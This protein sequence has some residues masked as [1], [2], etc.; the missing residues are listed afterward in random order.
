MQPRPMTLSMEAPREGC[1]AAPLHAFAR[2]VPALRKCADATIN[3]RRTLQR[4]AQVKI[5]D[6]I[7]KYPEMSL[8]VWGTVEAQLK[9]RAQAEQQDTEKWN[10]QYKKLAKLPTYWMASWLITRSAG[11]VTPEQFE[12]VVKSK[13]EQ[14]VRELFFY[15]SQTSATDNLPAECRDKL[16]CAKVFHA[17]ADQVGDRF[18][19]VIDSGLFEG[20]NVSWPDFGPYQVVW[21]GDRAKAINHSS[22]DSIEINGEGEFT[23]KYTM[24]VAWSDTDAY[25][26]GKMAKFYMRDYFGPNEGPHKTKLPATGL[27]DLAVKV[28][29]TVQKA[30]EE[31][32]ADAVIEDHA[33]LPD[34]TLVKRQAALARAR[35]MLANKRAKLEAGETMIKEEASGE[36][37]YHRMAS[38]VRPGPVK[39]EEAVDKHGALSE[40]DGS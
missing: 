16:V 15:V 39:D 12:L 35:Q 40:A 8:E 38:P 25:V 32:V 10:E 1:D 2:K 23:N 26:K 6:A 4:N 19:C 18:K 28:S 34:K 11:S 29:S 14:F 33:V 13:G 20:A 7:M 27:Q 21:D 9:L 36:N 24:H 22:G 30:K 31:L 3:Q 5:V 17:R 37:A